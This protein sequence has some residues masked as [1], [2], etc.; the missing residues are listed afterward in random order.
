[1]NPCEVQ[2]SIEPNKGSMAMTYKNWVWVTPL[3]YIQ[4]SRDKNWG[5]T[6]RYQ[7]TKLRVY[8][9]IVSR[10][11]SSWARVVHVT[12]N[13]ELF[14]AFRALSSRPGVVHVNY[15]PELFIASRALSSRPVAIHVSHNPKLLITSR[16][17]SSWPRVGHINHSLELCITSKAIS[18]WPECFM[19]TIG[20]SYS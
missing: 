20:L 12:H 15:S 9:F 10:G 6:H 5:S 16:T 14:V 13:P 2:K 19:L 11:L 17:M 8:M 4:V 7:G 1:M 3:R 18:S